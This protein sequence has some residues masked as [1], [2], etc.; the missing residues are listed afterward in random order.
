MLII[1]GAV[2]DTRSV[3]GSTP[4]H[5]AVRRGGVQTVRL[6]LVYGADVNACDNRGWTPSRWKST[7]RPE[8]AELLAEY[9]A[10]SGK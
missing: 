1:R 6:L 3:F 7:R 10:K 4:L 2:L 5:A 9:G 8:M